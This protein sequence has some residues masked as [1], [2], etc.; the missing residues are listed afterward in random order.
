MHM[1]QVGFMRTCLGAD[2]GMALPLQGTHANFGVLFKLMC[3]LSGLTL[4]W[5]AGFRG[6]RSEHE[7]K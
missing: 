6:Q 7:W 3:V 2:S 4:A 5:L 1:R